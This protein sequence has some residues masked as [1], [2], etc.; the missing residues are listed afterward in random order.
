MRVFLRSAALGLLIGSGTPLCVAAS[1]SPPKDASVE[2]G[3]KLLREGDSQA[4]GGQPTDAEVTY[5]KAMEQLLPGIRRLPF[6]HEVK[7]DVTAREEIRAYLIKEMAEEQ[8]PA[9]VRAEELSMKALGLLPADTDYQELMLRVY[10]EEI[11]AFYDPKTKTMHLIKEPGTGRKAGLFESLL[12]RKGG[13]SKDESK[14]VIAHELTHALAD[15]HF[16]LYRMQKAIKNDDD[17]ELALSA[18][19]EGEATLVMMGA[20]M[21]DWKGTE[22]S[23]VPAEQLGSV[24]NLMMPLLKFASGA[25]MRSAPPIVGESMLFPYLR[26]L[27]FCARLTNE[28]DWS[29]IDDAY[30]NP[31]L[32]TE[33]ILHPEKY[34][35]EPDAPQAVDL[36]KLET[37]PEWKPL[38]RNVV[39]EMQLGVL[40][41]RQDGKAAAAGWDGDQFAT[42]EGPDGHLGL[43]WRSTWDTEADAI[44][45]T[46]AY[47]RFRDSRIG[48]PAAPDS[49]SISRQS[50]ESREYHLERRGQEV[51]VVEGFDADTT[52]RLLA[53]A[54]AAAKVE[55]TATPTP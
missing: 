37:G 22:I 21:E 30:R 35:T 3:K 17:R 41:R 4:D 19:I 27:V 40:L 14:T 16:D 26:G 33:Q 25:S 44:E 1:D 29:A 8:E 20:Q 18:L 42:F 51:A 2:A 24:F 32:S 55:K 13:F 53:S 9:E 38:T 7:R 6:K 28:D 50:H 48:R 36:G 39:G 23:E 52:T 15:Q 43:V 31:P 47:A 11:G 10:S 45:F 34:R 49:D 5:Q 12:G 46:R 54:F